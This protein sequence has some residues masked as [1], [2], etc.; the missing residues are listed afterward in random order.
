MNRWV[1]IAFAV[2]VILGIA[3]EHLNRPSLS[4]VRDDCVAATQECMS[5]R[6]KLAF[7]LEKLR[8]VWD[9]ARRDP[10]IAARLPHAD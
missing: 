7:D 9:M 1:P 4:A 10:T 3:V 5:E 8:T 2:G 6:Q